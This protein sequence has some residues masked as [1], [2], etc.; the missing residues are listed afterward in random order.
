MPDSTLESGV[1][2]GKVMMTM[3]PETGSLEHRLRRDR[4]LSCS[5]FEGSFRL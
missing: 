2:E 3:M 1:A 5:V 4:R